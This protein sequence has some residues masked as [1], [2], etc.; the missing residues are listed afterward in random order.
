MSRTAPTSTGGAAGAKAAL[1]GTAAD[2]ASGVG[3]WTVRQGSPADAESVAGAVTELLSEL[4]ATPSPLGEMQAAAR[5][6]LANPDAGAVL[7]A[8]ADGQP[9]GVLAVSWQLAIHAAGRYAL[10]QD[11]W[12]HPS[13][14]VKGVGSGLVEELLELTRRQGIAKVE[15]G[16][17]RE[18]FD[19]LAATEKFYRRNGFA[20]LGR[21]MRMELE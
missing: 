12:V 6:L 3:D 11:L 13:W 18:S 8:E 21:R 14:R 20:P 17:P 9:V 15:V 19:G 5:S 4:G 10:I 2:G 16:L 1:G 7:I